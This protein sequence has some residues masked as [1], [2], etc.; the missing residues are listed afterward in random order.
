MVVL[1]LPCPVH[2]TVCFTQLIP[3]EFHR[4]IIAAERIRIKGDYDIE[5]M[6]TAENAQEQM[7]WAERFITIAQQQLNHST[8]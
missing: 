1:T 5:Q 8:D 2:I 4:A 3:T 7:D 6:I